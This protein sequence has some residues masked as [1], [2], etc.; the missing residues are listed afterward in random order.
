MKVFKKPKFIS[1]VLL[2]LL[3][4]GLTGCGFQVVSTNP[5]N[6]ATGVD[7]NVIIA[8]TFNTEAN[9]ATVNAETFLVK[10]SLGNP[11]EGTV[12]SSKKVATFTPQSDLAPSMDFTVTIKADVKDFLGIPMGFDYSF[13]FTTAE[14]GE[15]EIVAGNGVVQFVDVEGGC[16]RIVGDNGIHYEPINLSDE[17]KKDG[18]AVQFEVKFRRDLATVCMVGAIV[19]IISIHQLPKDEQHQQNL[20]TE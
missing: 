17:F 4:A 19:E 14:S 16:W 3:T 9:P 7:R 20:S 5:T 2:V 11:V 12:S 1:F 15:E 10:D 18:L 8:A 13:S 6:G